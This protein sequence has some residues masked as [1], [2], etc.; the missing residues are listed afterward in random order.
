MDVAL[1]A[2]SA[3]LVV[4]TCIYA[5]FTWQMV[6]EM[7]ETRLQA[8]RPRLGLYVRPY[9]PTGGNLA[10]VSLG[11]GAALE[12]AVALQFEP[13]GETRQ[14]SAPVFVPGDDAEFFFPR[15]EKHELPNFDELERQ[16]A[17]ATARGTMRD[18]AG[19][20][21]EVSEHVDA[22]AWWRLVSAAQQHYVEAP[23]ERVAHEMKKVR[24]TLE[25]IR[26]AVART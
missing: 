10:L 7:K 23:G 22:A 16:N 13:A 12:V 26:S 21:H 17:L 14:W 20:V 3:A 2:L 5:Y 18:I 25:K 1:V 6:R 15:A 9:G 19:N 4:V 8:I 11:P 24:E